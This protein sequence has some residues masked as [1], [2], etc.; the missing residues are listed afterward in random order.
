MDKTEVWDDAD[1]VDAFCS[2]SSRTLVLL[3]LSKKTQ[4]MLLGNILSQTDW[5][6]NATRR[7]VALS[8]FT[9]MNEDRLLPIRGE[10]IGRSNWYTVLKQ[11]LTGTFSGPMPA[12]EDPVT[13][14]RVR[15]KWET[16]PASVTQES[17][18]KF[19][20]RSC[21][22]RN[23]ANMKLFE[24]SQ[25]DPD[26]LQRFASYLEPLQPILFNSK[27]RGIEHLLSNFYGGV[28]ICY[29]RDRFPDVQIQKLF[30]EFISCDDEQF[31]KYL[32]Q[33]QPGKQFTP[34]KKK[35]WFRKEGE[36]MVPIR[37]ILAK[38]TGS[39]V[40]SSESRL[41]KRRRQRVLDAANDL[42]NEGVKLVNIRIKD[43]LTSE[44]RDSLMLQCLRTKFSHRPFKD[45]LLS[46]GG[47]NPDGNV[48]PRPLHETP[49]K[50]KA[51]LWTWRPDNTSGDLLGTLIGRVRAEMFL[52][53]DHPPSSRDARSFFSTDKNVEKDS[54][55]LVCPIPDT[56]KDYTTIKDFQDNASAAKKTAF[57]HTVGR[58][59]IWGMNKWGTV[60]VSTHGLGVAYL[61]LRIEKDPKHMW[62][63]NRTF[64]KK[65]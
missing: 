32:E 25:E 34:L 30:D 28:E 60:Y 35:Y 37:G 18:G 5:Y 59:I 15:F 20:E 62:C 4:V 36:L 61:H 26:G 12:K 48:G 6:V 50:G 44:Q 11:M 58:C 47:I 49:L 43:A 52:E 3:S 10:D 27:V 17:F 19:T 16:T 7:K 1:I 29:M 41:L 45:L 23:K 56:G 31:V 46:T 33:L 21:I 57:W 55:V 65:T 14:E 13:G 24:I 53:A 42:E 22:P 2:D 51:G 64:K 8:L 54:I 38:L 39:I 9:R 40:K 63:L